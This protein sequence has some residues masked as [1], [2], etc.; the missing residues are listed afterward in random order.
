MQYTE[1]FAYR[2]QQLLFNFPEDYK[3]NDGSK[4]WSGSK[5]VPHPI[6]Y[7]ADDDL[8]FLFVKNY[9]T[10]LEK[11]EYFLFYQI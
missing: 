11:K 6:P 9:A 10:I 3:N 5:R 1:N 8:A 7:N 4:F 2:I